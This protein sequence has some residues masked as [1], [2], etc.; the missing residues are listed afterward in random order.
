MSHVLRQMQKGDSRH[1]PKGV[2][3]NLLV[4]PAKRDRSA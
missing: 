3:W 4:K 1:E 2:K